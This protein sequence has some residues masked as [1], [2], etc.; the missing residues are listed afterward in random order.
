MKFKMKDIIVQSVIDAM[1]T[2]SIVEIA[3]VKK[4]ADNIDQQTANVI[5]CGISSINKLYPMT[6][7]YEYKLDVTI[8]S[9]IA[10]DESGR[11][12]EELCN[13]VE[14]CLSPL[15]DSKNFSAILQKP[16][17]GVVGDGQARQA[18][19]DINIMTYSYLVY[20]SF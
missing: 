6:E 10:D 12:F 7:D 20:A 9:W 11:Q 3:D 2:T 4:L 5:V 15:N 8:R 16:V 17:V 19:E 1:E 18:T 14:E 13:K